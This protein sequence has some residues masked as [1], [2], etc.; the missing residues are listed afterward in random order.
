MNVPQFIQSTVD[1]HLGC[2]QLLVIEKK[3]CDESSHMCVLVHRST[4]FCMV[5]TWN[6]IARSGVCISTV[7]EHPCLVLSVFNFC[8][9]REYRMVFYCFNLHSCD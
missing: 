2:F 4:C 3:C 5:Y 1:A 7:K 9:S 8:Q 6:G